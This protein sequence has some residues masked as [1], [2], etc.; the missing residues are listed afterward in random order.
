M[1]LIISTLVALLAMFAI[2]PANASVSTDSPYYQDWT[3]HR[4]IIVKASVR[5]KTDPSNMAAVAFIESKFK[6]NVRRGL[7][8]FD[9]P[10]WNVMLKEFGPK[11]GLSKRT[12]MTDPMANALMAAELWKKNEAFLTAK[13]G[14]PATASETYMAH[15][16]GNGG[17]LAMLRAKSGRTAQSVTPMQARYNKRLFYTKG[18][19]LTVS[20]FRV[21]MERQMAAP[22]RTFGGEARARALMSHDYAYN[23]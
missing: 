6:G 16:L 20:Q 22:K 19:A 17:A 7:Y 15:F 23:R 14:R 2:M 8:Q 5:A 18:K 1:K 13:L 9:R 4:A 3:K 21:A 10:T 12:K 11:Y